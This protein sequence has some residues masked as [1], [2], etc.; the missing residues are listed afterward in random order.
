MLRASSKCIVY[1]WKN[2]YCVQMWV[3][4][5]QVIKCLRDSMSGSLI[6]Y[7]ISYL[8]KCQWLMVAWWND[9]WLN[10]CTPSVRMKQSVISVA[11]KAPLKPKLGICTYTTSLLHRPDDY[12]GFT[13]TCPPAFYNKIAPIVVIF[14][15]TSGDL[16]NVGKVF[17]VAHNRCMVR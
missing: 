9:S 10:V 14:W 2:T 4:I 8:V 6:V 11:I 5:C 1:N 3:L 16:W 17:Q 12:I 7:V 13:L 15:I